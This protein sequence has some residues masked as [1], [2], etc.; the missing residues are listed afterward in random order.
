MN[1]KGRKEGN[2]TVTSFLAKLQI[3]NLIVERV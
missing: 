3:D 2:L 1:V